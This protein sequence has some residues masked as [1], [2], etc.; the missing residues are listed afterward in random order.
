MAGTRLIVGLGNPGPKYAGSRHN[1]GFDTIDRIA[2]KIGLP[3]DESA[4]LRAVHRLTGSGLYHA[5]KGKHRGRSIVLAKPTAFMNR[6]GAA[7]KKMKGRYGVDDRDILVVVDDIYL[8]IGTLRIRPSGGSGGHN[9][10]QDIID[11]LDSDNFPRIR[12][13]VGGSF[14]RGR[15]AEYVLE[16][17]SG[18]ERPVVDEM[19]DQA[20]DAALTFV[21]EGVVTAMN[22]FNQRKGGSS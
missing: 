1:V 8:D 4:L 17:F 2:D 3:M 20:A 16:S 7:V 9:G 6:S 12:I 5:A 14:R 11:E 19:I 15:Q 13:G 21:T 10:V 22:R 18:D